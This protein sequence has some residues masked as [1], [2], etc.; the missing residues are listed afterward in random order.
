M[1]KQKKKIYT[2]VVGALAI[3][4]ASSAWMGVSG[5][6]TADAAVTDQPVYSDNFNA[7]ALS[8]NWTATNA[9]IAA[10]YSSLR[11]Q[12]TE[13]AWPGHILC[14]GYKLD[15][16][17]RLVMKVQE[18][19]IPNASWFALSFGVPSTVSIFE[20]ASGALIFT[21]EQTLLFKEGV[22]QQKNMM[23]SPRLAEVATVELDFVKRTDGEYDITYTVK[24]GDT[25]LGSTLIE[26]FP[27]QDGYF[28][29]NTYGTNFDVLSF[30]V[31]EGA[32]KA[33]ADD[34]T[35]SKMSYDDNAVKGAEWVA[36]NPYKSNSAAIAPV[37]Q[38]DVSKIGA[39]ATYKA[40]F[41][42]KS[43]E[44]STLYELSAKFD[45]SAAQDG[46]ATG[47]EIGKATA[48][49]DGAFVGITRNGDGYKMV[50]SVGGNKAEKPLSGAP[51]DGVWDV[52][53]AAQYDNSIEIIANGSSTTFD[54]DISL[55]GYFGLATSDDYATTGVGALVD[56]FSYQRYIYNDMGAQDM[57]M[58]FEGT[59]EFED[60]EGKYYQY[61]VSTKDWHTGSNVRVANYGF[62]ENGYLLFG[63]SAPNSSFGPKVKFGDCVVRFDV[64]FVGGDY[65]YD[66]PDGDPLACNGECL[67]LQFGLKSYQ[68]IYANAQSLGVATYNGKSV[69]YTTNCVRASGDDHVYRANM[70]HTEENE[71]DLFRKSATYNF[72]YVI[73]NGTVTM[74]FKEAGEDESVL[75]IVREYVTGVE[76]NGYLAVYG[77][78]GVDFRLDNFSVTSLD[79]GY[80]SSE[81]KGGQDIQT[82]RADLS[83]GDD[84]SAFETSG[85][86]MTTKGVVGSHIARLTLG[87]VNGLT[88]KHG[89]LTITFENNGAVVTDGVTRQ[90]ISFD[91]PLLLSGATVEISRIA[92]RV[93]IGFANAGAPLAAID[94]N[95]Y[96][97]AGLKAAN[98]DRIVLSANGSV[99]LTKV[100]IF[101]LDSKVTIEARNF[102]ASIDI[103]QP[104]V[105]RDSI[106]GKGVDTW[107]WILIGV[108]A[109]AA[110]ATPVVIILMR[111]K[112]KG[113]TNE[114]G[115]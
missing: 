74:H 2:A 111:K 66:N 67:G 27:V 44:V 57:N 89:D 78:N 115:E 113:G 45:F 16:D 32:E 91:K 39:S 49:A 63:N 48:D 79:R 61:Y 55:S 64:T 87:Q 84:L 92:D 31:Y 82:L 38:L 28:G 93:S 42:V 72:M 17:C 24:D 54:L 26:K 86:G 52:T 70:P 80:T 36:L 97:A 60:E 85:N 76:T 99:T 106:Q 41:E 21:Q 98:R 22:D 77:A 6:Y 101:N 1:K 110:I 68:N 9:S 15:G 43:T 5:W 19:P 33:Y 12:P 104:W 47:F 107:V 73:K 109:A 7:Q 30:D 34:F 46:V 102:D 8:D 29:F 94:S 108:V 14:Q 69:Y 95:T 62:T 20:K 35:T 58:N 50:L 81:Y 56:D 18:L 83:K 112:K 103:M 88:Y 11:V 10:D 114:K 105:V 71:Y 23:Y 37:G 75:G 25:V 3:A 100:A 40:P 4:C 90:T 65:Y 53:L 59:R 51:A 13:Y 96:E